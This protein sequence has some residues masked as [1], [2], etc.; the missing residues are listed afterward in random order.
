MNLFTHKHKFFQKASENN[1]R[2]IISKKLFIIRKQ[3]EKLR[4]QFH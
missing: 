2:K 3:K 4:K 1:F